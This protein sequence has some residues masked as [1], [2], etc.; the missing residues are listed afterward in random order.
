MYI[1]F[2]PETI[3]WTN[4]ALSQDEVFKIVLERV[5]PE[6]REIAKTHPKL[7]EY[8]WVMIQ[9]F[10]RM[11]GDAWFRSNNGSWYWDD[12]LNERIKA[13]LPKEYFDQIAAK[14]AAEEAQVAAQQRAIQAARLA[15]T[16]RQQALAE[17]KR[18]A[19]EQKR[20][21]EAKQIAE[22]KRLAEEQRIAEEQRAAEEK[23]LA[24]VVES[25][26]TS[27]PD[28][29]DEIDSAMGTGVVEEK[30]TQSLS[31]MGIF[32]NPAATDVVASVE[33]KCISQ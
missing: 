18:L 13:E 25:A 8:A 5:I 23:H 19:E 15:E 27:N 26:A 24:T 4:S 16:L 11:R 9:N 3:R 12:N 14:K 21:A 7:H 6:H 22:E 20:A 2:N 17:Q 28:L 29:F 31:T 30:I 10:T 32:S 33:H 1:K